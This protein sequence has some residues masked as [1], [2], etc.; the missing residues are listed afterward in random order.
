MIIGAGAPPT[1]GECAAVDHRDGGVTITRPGWAS[2]CG[3]RLCR[4]KKD[5]AG[6]EDGAE[7][8]ERTVD[9]DIDDFLHLGDELEGALTRVRRGRGRPAGAPPLAVCTGRR[10]VSVPGTR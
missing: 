6:G 3:A 8:A 4:R 5:A 9:D 2:R 7:E 10:D 1:F